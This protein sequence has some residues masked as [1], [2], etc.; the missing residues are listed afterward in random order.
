MPTP[1]ANRARK[2]IRP[3]R[4]AGFAAR[5]SEESRAAILR[6]A[7]EEFASEGVAGARTERIAAAAGVNK[8]LLYYYFA[9]K[10]S[11]YG[12]VLDQVFAAVDQSLLAAL[13]SPGTPAECILRYVGAHFDVLAGRPHMPRVVLH[14][15]TRASR[16]SSSPHLARIAEKHTRPIAMRLQKVLQQGI[17]EGQFRQ[18]DVQHFVFTLVANAVFYFGAAPM[19]RAVTGREPLSPEMLAAR[20]AAVLDFVRHALFIDPESPAPGPKR[21][22]RRKT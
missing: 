20:R 15:M 4:R 6:A 11:L 5:N 7:M 14:E 22:T 13:D 10:E 2:T 8:A 3:R 17:A 16:E 1:P 12:A 9:D 18:V 19:I 21:H